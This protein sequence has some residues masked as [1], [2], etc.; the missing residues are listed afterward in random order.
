[1]VENDLVVVERIAAAVVSA[2]HNTN[3]N[4][5]IVRATK[6]GVKVV[7]GTVDVAVAGAWMIKIERV[8][9]VMDC[10]DDRKLRLATFLLK[11]GAYD[12]WQSS[13]DQISRPFYYNLDRFQT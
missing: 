4:F 10:P 11:D 13:A 6:I 12:W 1:M 8:F 2:I 9:D 7:T 3:K 5:I